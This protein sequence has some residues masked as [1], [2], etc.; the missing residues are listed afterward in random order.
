MSRTYFHSP[1]GDAE[2]NG[3]EQH[4]FRSIVYDIAVDALGL[5]GAD[6]PALTHHVQAER[7]LHVAVDGL[8]PLRVDL[9]RL[10]RPL[11]EARFVGA[12]ERAAIDNGDGQG[13][14]YTA[15]A[16]T[17]WFAGFCGFRALCL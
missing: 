7:Q 2:L 17:P 12:G 3:S 14:G 15:H 5:L 6:D 4:H 11:L 1:S 16:K 10:D 13:A 9:Q 8:A